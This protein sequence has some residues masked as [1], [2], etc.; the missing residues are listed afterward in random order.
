M[1]WIGHGKQRLALVGLAGAM[2]A[3]GFVGCASSE[4]RPVTVLRGK[5]TGTNNVTGP[6]SP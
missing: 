2:A 3:I 1:C 6:G 5:S 4:G